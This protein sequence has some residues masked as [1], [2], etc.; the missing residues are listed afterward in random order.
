MWWRERALLRVNVRQ[1]E[2]LLAGTAHQVFNSKYGIY[3]LNWLFTFFYEHLKSKLKSCVTFW[4]QPNLILI[5]W[6]LL[7]VLN[8]IILYMRNNYYSRIRSLLHVQVNTLVYWSIS[9]QQVVLQF[10]TNY[11]NN[12]II[13]FHICITIF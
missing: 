6:Y 2:V 7:Y 8:V 12:N 11:Y 10:R 5:N 1:M 3:E 4:N 9:K 13:N